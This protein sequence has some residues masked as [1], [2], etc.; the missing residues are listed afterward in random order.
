MWLGALATHTLLDAK[1]AAAPA[2]EPALSA[3]Q[4]GN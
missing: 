3:K 2:I 4:T 1:A